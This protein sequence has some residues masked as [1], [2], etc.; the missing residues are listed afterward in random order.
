MQDQTRALLPAMMEARDRFMELI[1]EIRPEL[2]RYCARMTGSVFDGEDVVQETLAKAYFALGQMTQPPNLRPWLFRIAHNTAMDFLKRYDRQHVE[3]VADLPER[4]QRE[5]DGI[6]PLLVEAALSAFTEL[7]PVQRSAVILKDVL[8]QSLEDA[9]STMGTTVGAV[10]AALSRGRANIARAPH[11]ATVPP[12]QRL[13]E[14]KQTTLRRY[15]D[16]FNAHDW[17]GLRALLGDESRLDVVSRVQQRMADAGYCDRY[18]KYLET[19][20]LR[21]R[22]G[23]VDG[24]PAIAMFSPA[25]S[26][27]PAYFVLLETDAGKIALVRDFRYVPYIARDARFL[28]DRDL[29]RF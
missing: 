4:A 9:A 25:T 7:P 12:G 20:E 10:K 19:E 5:D 22:A 13:S 15:V 17:D 16:L 14:E 29:D 24:V 2:H 21:A 28:P 18:A 6:D 23:F 27:Q 8:G 1:D 3:P 26:R 11:A